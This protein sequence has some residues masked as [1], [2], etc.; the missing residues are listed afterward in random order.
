MHENLLIVPAAIPAA[1][2]VNDQCVFLL[3]LHALLPGTKPS[4][5]RIGYPLASPDQRENAIDASSSF[6]KQ[7]KPAIIQYQLPKTLTC[8]PSILTH[9]N[10]PPL[11]FYDCLKH[12]EH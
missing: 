7:P 10:F 12:L 9:R 6:P 5:R 8:P 4:S 3:P 2:P 11:E 1:T